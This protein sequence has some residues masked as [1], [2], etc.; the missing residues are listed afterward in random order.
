MEVREA[1]SRGST[2]VLRCPVEVMD[3]VPTSTI[4]AQ[5]G[6]EAVLQTF[7][8][9]G[10]RGRRLRSQLAAQFPGRPEEQIEDAIQIACRSFLAEA[11]GMSEPGRIY[12]WIRT[13]AYHALLRELEHLGWERATDPVE[14]GRTESLVAEADPTEEL[15]ALEDGAELE[16]LVREVA[17]SLP[18][19]RRRVLAL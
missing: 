11:E 10:E 4:G 5:D 18:G 6:R 7:G 8:R 16:V 1:T 13:A 15:I 17:D 14:L 2:S 9:E 19:R 3:P 12:A